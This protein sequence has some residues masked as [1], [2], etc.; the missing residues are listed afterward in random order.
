MPK[1]N[2]ESEKP[3]TLIARVHIDTGGV[4]IKTLAYDVDVVSLARTVLPLA[5]IAAT[6][7]TSAAQIHRRNLV[8]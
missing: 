2:P 4:A 1:I 5:A 8:F 6:L 3:V 7:V